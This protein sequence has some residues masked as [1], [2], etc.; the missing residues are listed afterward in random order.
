MLMNDKYSELLRNF[1]QLKALNGNL[2]MEM[3]K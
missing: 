1:E 2:V 3:N